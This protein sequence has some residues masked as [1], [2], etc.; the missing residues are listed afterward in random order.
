[1]MGTQMASINDLPANDRLYV[2]QSEIIREKAAQGPCVLVGAAQTTFSGITR[3]GS[4]WFI[5]AGDTFRLKRIVEEYGA[6]PK[7]RRTSCAAPIKSV[8]S[9]ITITPTE[10][11]A[12]PLT[13]SL[14]S[15]AASPALRAEPP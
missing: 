4:A 11:G 13:I 10:N 9:T 7:K 5:H 15:T 3:S 12:M 8:P 6:D 1:M 14:P 2:I